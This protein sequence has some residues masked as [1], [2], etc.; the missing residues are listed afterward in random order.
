MGK[1]K[2]FSDP[3]LYDVSQKQEAP[4]KTGASHR[5]VGLVLDT[6]PACQPMFS[7]EASLPAHVFVMA[8]FPFQE[9]HEDMWGKS[10]GR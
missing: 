7:A 4:A 10:Q 8:A 6:P 2:N 5:T 1:G 9:E 3:S